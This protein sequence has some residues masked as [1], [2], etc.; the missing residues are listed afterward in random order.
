M[1]EKMSDFFNSRLDGYEEHQLHAIEQAE[2]F[3]PITAKQLPAKAHARVLDLGC[4]TGLELGYYFALNPTAEVTGID[5]AGDMLNAL[6]AK[7]PD[8][9]LTLIQESYFTVPF[10][11]NCYDAVVSVESLHHFTQ[12][13][14]IPLYQKAFQALVPGGFLI[15]TDYFAESDEQEA[16]FRSELLR[17][18]AEQGIQDGEFYH[19]DTPLTVAHEV[20]ALQKAGFAHVEELGH[21]GNTHLLR[22]EK[23]PQSLSGNQEEDA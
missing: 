14:K 19:Y 9:A 1:L 5:L 23:G 6:R 11:K 17:L 13:E 4:G 16:F 8:K 2:T 18:K 21:W 22:A 15:L 3:Y 7:F 20:E 12:A 10:P